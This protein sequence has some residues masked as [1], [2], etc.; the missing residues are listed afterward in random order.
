M[1]PQET[2]LEPW[3]QTSGEELGGQKRSQTEPKVEPDGAEDAGRSTADKGRASGK[4]EPG[5]AIWLM[6]SGGAEGGRSQGRA[7]V[8]TDRGGVVG[9]EVGGGTRG[10]S[11]QGGAGGLKMLGR[12]LQHVGDKEMLKDTSGGEAEE[13]AV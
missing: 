4:R 12:F 9:L 2:E 13:L 8:S 7:D 11:G 6:V 1:R 10:S 5:E 3:G